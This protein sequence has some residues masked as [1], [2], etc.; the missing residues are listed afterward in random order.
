MVSSGNLPLG[1]E[2]DSDA[3]FN[4]PLNKNKTRFVS[5][6]MSFYI[7]LSLNPDITESEIKGKVED[8]IKSWSIPVKFDIDELVVIKD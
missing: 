7:N 1:A 2:V 8:Y 3:P 4:E 6:S 5:L